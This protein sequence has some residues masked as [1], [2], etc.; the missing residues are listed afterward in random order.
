M[1]TSTIL[2][3]DSPLLPFLQLLAA[4]LLAVPIAWDRERHERSAGLRTFPLVALG[5]C[6]YVLLAL[7][8]AGEDPSAMGRAIQGLITG[9]GFLGGGAILKDGSH[10]H[11]TATAA[12]IWI[13]AA[14][15]A[16]VGFGQPLVALALSLA[17]FF[18]MR[19]VTPIKKNIDREDE[20]EES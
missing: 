2:P 12:S 6:G 14:M 20:A 1:D 10:V 11:G 16:A 9:I 17:T 15:G 18:T 3:P 4:Y 19:F 13:T 7:S 5:S 8:V